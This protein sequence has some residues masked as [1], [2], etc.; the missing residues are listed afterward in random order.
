MLRLLLKSLFLLARV[1][2]FGTC[3]RVDVHCLFEVSLITSARKKKMKRKD[4]S[5]S[6]GRILVI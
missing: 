3:W 2:S 6:T 5:V 4:I 1:L